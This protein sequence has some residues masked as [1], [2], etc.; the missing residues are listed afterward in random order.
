MDNQLGADVGSLATFA[1]MEQLLRLFVASGTITPDEFHGLMTDAA[2][3]FAGTINLVGRKEAT[4]AI[5]DL[6][7]R[8]ESTSRAGKPL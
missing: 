8:V 1:I 2:N 4:A 6:M 7:K 3:S 5:L